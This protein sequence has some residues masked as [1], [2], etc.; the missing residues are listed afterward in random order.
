M[1]RR[2]KQICVFVVLL[3]RRVRVHFP[4]IT[5]LSTLN[6]VGKQL[7]NVRMRYVAVQHYQSYCFGHVL[8][9]LWDQVKFSPTVYI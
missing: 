2:K 6:L 8:T 4:E 5:H 1:T 3:H 7:K 9:T